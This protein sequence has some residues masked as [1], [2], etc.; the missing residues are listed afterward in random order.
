MTKPTYNITTFYP[1]VFDELAE[2][3][4]FSLLEL[5]VAATITSRTIYTEATNIVFGVHTLGEKA[6]ELPSNT[7]VFNLEQLDLQSEHPVIREWTKLYLALGER[8]VIWDYSTKNLAL[9][10]EFGVQAKLFEFGYQKSLNRIYSQHSGIK[11]DIDVL[12]YGSTN[13]R[14]KKVLDELMARGLR[15]K[16]LFN[17]YGK[18]RDE[19]IARA[20]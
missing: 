17:V 8:F 10:Q 9:W 19:W 4:Y 13:D 1:G 5:G 12:F 2:L 20:K 14:R 6:L 11:Q 18:Q 3:L 15:F 16:H 7:I